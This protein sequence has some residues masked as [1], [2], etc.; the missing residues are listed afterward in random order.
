MS[1][2]VSSGFFHNL[3][4]CTSWWM[5]TIFPSFEC[6]CVCPV[7]YSWSA[8]HVSLL[9]QYQP[10][11]WS[12]CVYINGVGAGGVMLWH[13]MKGRLGRKRHSSIP[14]PDRQ[15][16]ESG[17]RGICSHT[18]RLRGGTLMEE[19]VLAPQLSVPVGGDELNG[20]GGREKEREGGRRQQMKSVLLGF[21][22]EGRER[23]DPGATLREE[24]WC[25]CC[26]EASA[27]SQSVTG[28]HWEGK[29]ALLS[30]GLEL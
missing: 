3:K 4:Y 7:M 14:R 16:T 13:K 20:E 29:V 15:R 18:E 27:A 24:S 5:K 17:K 19:G 11:P 22:R 25:L 6:E 9:L 8:Q 10:W 23:G 21:E 12:I 26:E 2:W 30:K 1:V 28:G